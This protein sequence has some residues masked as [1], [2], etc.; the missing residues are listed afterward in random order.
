MK[1]K[2][3]GNEAVGA[4]TRCGGFYCIEHGRMRMLSVALCDS[5]QNLNTKIGLVSLLLVVASLLIIGI[6]SLFSK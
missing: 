2:D 3:C 1:C 5:C 6:A 4:C